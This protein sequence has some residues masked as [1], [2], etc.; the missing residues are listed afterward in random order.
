MPKI[1]ASLPARTLID[2]ATNFANP[3]SITT[4]G[5][6]SAE[7]LRT[8]SHP[9]TAQ[10]RNRRSHRHACAI[11]NPSRMNSVQQFPLR[12]LACRRACPGCSGNAPVFTRESSAPAPSDDDRDLIGEIDRNSDTLPAGTFG[13]WCA[14]RRIMFSFSVVPQIVPKWPL[15]R[16]P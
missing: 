8:S 13:G 7:P 6:C 2:I 9:F 4:S 16:M 10:M 15:L 12:D 5:P 3:Q 14:Y 11:R 1:H